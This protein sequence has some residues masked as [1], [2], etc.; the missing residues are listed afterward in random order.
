MPKPWKVFSL[1]MS[2]VETRLEDILTLIKALKSENTSVT[3]LTLRFMKVGH[4]GL[5]TI[6]DVL[7]HPNNKIDDLALEDIGD[8]DFSSFVESFKSPHF[9]LECLYISGEDKK[10]LTTAMSESGRQMYIITRDCYLNDI[11]NKLTIN[12]RLYWP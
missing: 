8:L 9:K 1:E 7:K 4:K 6:V 11:D 12:S 2:S 5:A 3:M 10:A